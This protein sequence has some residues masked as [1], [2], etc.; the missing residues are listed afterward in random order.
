M[1]FQLGEKVKWMAG[2]IEARGC[3]L[4][5]GENEGE[6]IIVVHYVGNRNQD[7]RISMVR[8]S[9]LKLDINE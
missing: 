2:Q 9:L 7:G 1:D 8:K 5:D 6:A 3:F 4:E